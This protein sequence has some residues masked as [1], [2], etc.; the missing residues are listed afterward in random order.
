MPDRQRRSR[1]QFQETPSTI[2]LAASYVLPVRCPLVIRGAG[3]NR[4][5]V[6]RGPPQRTGA[7]RKAKLRQGAAR[8]TGG[9]I[10][11]RG[12]RERDGA[13]PTSILCP[14]LPLKI[15]AQHQ[16]QRRTRSHFDAAEVDER[17]GLD[18]RQILL[19]ATAAEVGTTIDPQ[20]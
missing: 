15:A 7:Q 16:R 4:N 6:L 17:G 12:K 5:R 1:A 18:E 20:R 14:P 3:A 10:P 11:P 8:D 2:C 19:R 9:I 13:P